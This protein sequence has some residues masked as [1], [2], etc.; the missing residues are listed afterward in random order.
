[1]YT[2]EHGAP[3]HDE[4]VRDETFAPQERV[5]IAQRERVGRPRNHSHRG[6]LSLPNAGAGANGHPRPSP[7]VK[8]TAY[9]MAL[10]VGCA[11]ADLAAHRA[12]DRSVGTSAYRM[13]PFAHGPDRRT[14]ARRRLC[15]RD[16]L[17][18][19]ARRRLF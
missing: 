18:R 19:P 17:A 5:R 15:L 1:Q 14:V 16:R 12:F 2:C 13:G 6:R 7:P 3:T 11:S 10:G 4:V 8:W 9:Y